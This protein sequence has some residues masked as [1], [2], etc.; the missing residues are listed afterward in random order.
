MQKVNRKLVKR[1]ADTQ[2][3]RDRAIN[4]LGLFSDSDED[5]SDNSENQETCKAR[6]DSGTSAA[7]DRRLKEVTA[8]LRSEIKFQHTDNEC[9]AAEIEHFTQRC[10]ELSEELKEK[11]REM[12]EAIR[13]ERENHAESIRVQLRMNELYVDKLQ[14]TER[15]LAEAEARA[16]KLQANQQG[17]SPS[18]VTPDIATFQDM[19][20]G[21]TT[22]LEEVTQDSKKRKPN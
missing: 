22:Q 4:A 15:M 8:Y 16:D 7:F 18:N 20:S 19:L 6:E 12:A 3:S 11:E 10:S 21:L 17:D 2:N 1:L 14:L 9:K 5:D 13:T